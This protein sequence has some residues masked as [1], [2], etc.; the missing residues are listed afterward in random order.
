MTVT[1]ISP[2]T[3][4]RPVSRWE[5]FIDIFYAPAEVFRRRAA[6][7]FGLPMLVISVALAILAITNAGVMQPIMDAE[8]HR[9]TAAILRQN[10]QVT[11]D[12]LE[13]MKSFG[14]ATQRYGTIV[15]VPLVLLL[16][17]VMTWLVSKLV[18]SGQ[19]LKASILIA[20]FAWVPRVVEQIVNAVQGLLMNADQLTS[21]YA[22]QLGPARF[23]DADTTSPVVMTILGRLDLFTLWVTVL[24]AIGTYAVG[25]VPKSRA[26]VAGV[27]FWCVGTIFPLLGVLRQQ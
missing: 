27:L 23:F 14:E 20:C 25:M 4:S 8:F 6:D 19:T 26:A 1:E 3:S 12:A 18:D 15:V 10:P 17:G 11:A 2:P 7:G 9:Q 16:L 13:K 5:D 24:L 22:I 21:R